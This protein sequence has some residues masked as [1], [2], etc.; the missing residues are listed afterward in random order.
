MSKPI[1]KGTGISAAVLTIIAGVFA[2]EGGYVNDPDDPGGATN[3]GITQAV[4]VKHGYTG[5]MQELPKEF[6][7]NIYYEDY[8]VAPGFLP[9]VEL[10]PAVARKLI[11]AGVNT[12]TV[13]PSIWFQEVLNAYANYGQSYPQINVDGKVGPA[14]V[15]AYKALEKIRGKQK[16]CELVLKG[17]DAKQTVYYMSLERMQKYTVGWVDNRIGNVKLES[18]RI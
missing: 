13:R 9:I 6:A 18:C 17:L 15:N 2:V 10:Q 16:A 11:D 7:E 5:T 1:I 12:G 14:T 3:H 4:A 8:I